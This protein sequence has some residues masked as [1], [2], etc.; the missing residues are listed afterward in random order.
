MQ[1]LSE[2]MDEGILNNEEQFSYLRPPA[3]SRSI[4]AQSDIFSANYDKSVYTL[5]QFFNIFGQK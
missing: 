2:A 5:E 4:A 3:I 1:R